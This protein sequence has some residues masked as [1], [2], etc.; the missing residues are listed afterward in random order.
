MRHRLPTLDQLA[1][2]AREAGSARDRRGGNSLKS[3][4]NLPFERARIWPPLGGL[5]GARGSHEA[6]VTVADPDPLQGPRG[7]RRDLDSN[8]V[9]SKVDGRNLPSFIGGNFETFLPTTPIR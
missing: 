1:V 9:E 2:A 4:S 7:V 6:R 5:P 8:R 3:R